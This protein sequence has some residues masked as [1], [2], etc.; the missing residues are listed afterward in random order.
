MFGKLAHHSTGVVQMMFVLI[1]K[2]TNEIMDGPVY[3]KDS[4]S[5]FAKRH[6]ISQ[7][8]VVESFKEGAKHL[9]K[10]QIS[11]MRDFPWRSGAYHGSEEK[12]TTTQKTTVKKTTTVHTHHKSEKTTT[13]VKATTTIKKVEIPAVTPKAPVVPKPVIPQVQANKTEE[14]PVV[15]PVVKPVVEPVVQKPVAQKPVAQK[16]A[17]QPVSQ[18]PV[19]KVVP[20][21]EESSP[22][23]ASVIGFGV[24]GAAGVGLMMFKRQSPQKYDDLK[25]KFPEAFGNLKRSVSR[26]ASTIKRGVTRSVSRR[27]NTQVNAPPLPASYSFTLSSED[28]LPRVALYDDPYPTKTHGAQHW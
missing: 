18:K 12:K 25:Q 16:P 27:G 2:D 9:N 15:K 7:S 4:L 5:K 24:V 8:A 17:E 10:H 3:S 6:G 14:T 22:V 21:N 11:G 20:E 1:N 26:G 23:A 13:V 19:E 28:G